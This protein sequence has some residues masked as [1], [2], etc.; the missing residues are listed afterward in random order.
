MRKLADNFRICG[1]LTIACTDVP[2]MRQF[3]SRIW[4]A[5]TTVYANGNLSN[6]RPFSSRICGRFQSIFFNPHIFGKYADL[7]RMCDLFY[8]QNAYMRPSKFNNALVWHK[9]KVCSKNPFGEINVSPYFIMAVCVRF[10][11]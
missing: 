11:Q 7:I 5:H 3:F 4:V 6:M 9:S 10:I 1:R 8:F 2:H